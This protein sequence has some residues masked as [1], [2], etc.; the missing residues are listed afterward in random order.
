MDEI[1]EEIKKKL[2]ELEKKSKMYRV[3][4]IVFLLLSACFFVL[5]IFFGFYL[6]DLSLG[7]SLLAVGLAYG[8]LMVSF[9][10]MDKL[11]SS[12]LIVYLKLEKNQDTLKNRLKK[13]ESK[14]D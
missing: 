14:L 13:L 3:A 9:G 8:T 10:E 2:R 1:H 6:D 12:L 11:K 4:K 5:A 7:L